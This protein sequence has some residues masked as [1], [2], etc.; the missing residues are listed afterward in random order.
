[1]WSV[2]G[3]QT[4]A[5]PILSDVEQCADMQMIQFRDRAGL[6]VKALAATWV[7]GEMLAEHLYRDDAL[8]ARVAG[9]IDFAHAAS[10]KER[11]DFIGAETRAGSERHGKCLGL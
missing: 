1:D 2:T 4:C 3:V 9:S 10:A 7:L 6:A 8:E 5:L 11:C